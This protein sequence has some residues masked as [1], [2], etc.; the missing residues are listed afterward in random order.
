LGIRELGLQVKEW[1]EL[2]NGFARD[3]QPAVFAADP[4]AVRSI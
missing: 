1:F 3:A 4:S 2:G